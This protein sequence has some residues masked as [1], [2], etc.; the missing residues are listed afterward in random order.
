ME[1]ELI[2]KDL[3][4]LDNAAEILLNFCKY[5]S[6]FA[7]YGEIGAGKTTF[8]KSLCKRI[9]V[10]EN[11]VSPSFAIINEY[12][13]EKTVFHMDFYR[14]KNENEALELDL[15]DYF[16]SDAWFFIEWPSKIE[17]LLPQAFVQVYLE[18]TN[19]QQRK[20]TIKK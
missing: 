7:F 11:V 12:M 18:V 1:K 14:L 5:E 10:K 8:I 16:A 19:D 2:I 4:E 20:I 6:F 15:E 17:N 13:G 9:G 3:G